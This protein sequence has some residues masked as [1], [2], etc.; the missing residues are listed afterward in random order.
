MSHNREETTTRA[1]ME[2]LMLLPKLVWGSGSWG[3]SMSLK[4]SG[5][6]S[7]GKEYTLHYRQSPVTLSSHR[8]GLAFRKL[9]QAVYPP[10]NAS[11]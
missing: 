4:S 1:D 8:Y 2:N 11:F 10:N 9:Y 5:V 6:T 7:A 3:H